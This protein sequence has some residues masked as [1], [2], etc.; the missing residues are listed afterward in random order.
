MLEV[1]LIA[2]LLLVIAVGVTVFFLGRQKRLRPDDAVLTSF[3]NPL[4]QLDDSDV[5]P[6][7]ADDVD[8]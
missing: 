4:Y 5:S 7:A 2:V 3:S 6:T 8:A 1:S